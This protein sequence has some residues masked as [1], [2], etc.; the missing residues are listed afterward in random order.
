MGV[1]N[2]GTY[3]PP[4]FPWGL[5]LLADSRLFL[6]EVLQ[7]IGPEVVKINTNLGEQILNRM[8]EIGALLLWDTGAVKVNLEQPFRL[9]SGNYS[10]IYINCREVISDPTFMRI[11]TAF[12]GALCRYRQIRM[13][14]VAGGETAGIPLAAFLAQS[15]SLPMAYVRKETKGHGIASLVEGVIRKSER[16]LLVEDLITDAGSKISFIDAIH[17]S[18]G[19]VE[20]VLVIFDREQG[21]R[22]ALEKIGV[23][24]HAITDMT[25]TL[26]VARTERFLEENEFE[27]VRLYLQ[28]PSQW[29]HKRGLNFRMG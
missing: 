18:G 11:F 13:D 29:L 20:D 26:E 21:G 6:K 12:A 5:R 16:V 23:R 10:P 15:L 22:E 17:T 25:T 27:S 7:Q 14:V 2:H 3:C 19:I 1:D 28:D 8:R 24:L 4:Y 9:V